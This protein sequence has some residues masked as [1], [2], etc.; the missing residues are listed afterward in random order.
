LVREDGSPQIFEVE[1]LFDFGWLGLG[2]ITFPNQQQRKKQ[3]VFIKQCKHFFKFK[4][5][6]LNIKVLALCGFQENS[7]FFL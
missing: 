4:I 7:Y 3:W 5:R 1:S 2:V 6:D